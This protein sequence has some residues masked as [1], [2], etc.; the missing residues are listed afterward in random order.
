MAG[1]QRSGGRRGGRTEPWVLRYSL[2]VV[3]AGVAAAAGAFL[4]AYR[5]TDGAEDKD[6]FDVA[7]KSATATA[8][9]AA[10][11]LTWGR[12]ELSRREHRLDADRDLT[13]RYSRAIEQVGNDQDL[14]V[15][16]GG[17]Y[18]LERYALDAARS[19]IAS[20]TDWR[21]A[22]DVLATLARELSNK[23]RPAT[24]EADGDGAATGAAVEPPAAV[25]EAVRVLGRFRA[26]SNQPSLV[27]P[28][29][30]LTG[31]LLANAD[32]RDADLRRAELWQAELQHA[33]LRGAELRG[34][35]LQHADLRGA[36]LRNAKLLGDATLQGDTYLEA[37]RLASVRYDDR[38]LWPEGFE[39]PANAERVSG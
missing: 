31:A 26:R 30:R 25:I 17:I 34:A 11:I 28:A 16:I 4:V 37:A 32:L 5:A 2:V 3:L 20:D 33:D 36:D 14:F 10:G 8:A 23:A 19:G 24:A 21:M 22:L 35:D 7:I 29:H 13:E 6:R 9:V 18:A 39:P 15:R 12:L 38:T 27:L 1:W